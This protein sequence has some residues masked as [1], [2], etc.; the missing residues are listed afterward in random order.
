[1]TDNVLSLATWNIH[2]GVGTD[3]RRDLNRIAAVIRQIDP[4]VIGLQEVDNHIYQAGDDLAAL[5]EMTGMQ[6]CAGPTMQKETGDYG[7]ALLT[8]LPVRKVERYPLNVPNREPR[9]LLIVHL[10]WQGEMIQIAV[11]HLGLQPG[12]RRVQ[13]RRLIKHLSIENRTPLILMGDFNEW[14]FWGRPLRWLYRHFG[15]VR[16]P[17][18]FPARWPFLRLDHI[19]SEPPDRL[20]SLKSCQLPLA[21]QASDHLPLIAKYTRA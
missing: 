13:V 4:D 17:A 6:A 10:E 8:H 7:N 2:M 14:L 21:R 20:Y 19:L 11:T 12:E 16:S 18:T 5:Q 15:K 3:R 1:M 9:G